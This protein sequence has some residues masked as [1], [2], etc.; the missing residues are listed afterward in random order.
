MKLYRVYVYECNCQWLA[1]TSRNEPENPCYRGM[2][3]VA[4]RNRMVAMAE[5]V[6]QA[7]RGAK[8]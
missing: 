7:R 4:A 2:F 5:A 8:E 6:E 1:S 3:Q